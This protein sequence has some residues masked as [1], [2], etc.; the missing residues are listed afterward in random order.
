MKYIAIIYITMFIFCVSACNTHSETNKKKYPDS[1]N[2]TDSLINSGGNYADSNY[3]E[4]AR[5][6]ASNDCLTCHRIEERINGPSYREVAARYG[7]NE[8]NVNNLA[9]SVIHGSKGLWGNHEMAPHP[10]ISV[11]EARKMVRYI[12]SLDTTSGSDS[13]R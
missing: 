10:N 12:L 4:G 5:L 9:Y 6:I 13:L 1:T 8:G 7:M 2:A 3:R 11:D